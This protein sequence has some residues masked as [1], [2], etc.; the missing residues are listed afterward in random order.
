[1]RSLINLSLEVSVELFFFPLSFLVLVSFDFVC[2]SLLFVVYFSSP[3]FDAYTQSSMLQSH[4][5]PLFSRSIQP[6]Y[7]ITLI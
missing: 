1:M 5:P 3:Y 7:V 2:L 6:F 4:L